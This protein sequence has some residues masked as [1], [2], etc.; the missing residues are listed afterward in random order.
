MKF[1]IDENLPP[2][3]AVWLCERGHD[4]THLQ[5]ANL[6][7]RNDAAIIERAA[8]EGR[9][10]LTK[11]GDFADA[12]VPVVQLLVGNVSTR[13]LIA[14]FENQLGP[15]EAQLLAGSTKILIG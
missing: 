2:R 15:I 14:W 3:L 6:V 9:V 5:R 4:A 8:S 10:I 13:A 1:L 11:D 7:G 12:A